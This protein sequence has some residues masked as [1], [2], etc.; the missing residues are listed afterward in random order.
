[1][2]QL[3]NISLMRI[4]HTDTA[5][6]RSLSKSNTF[7]ATFTTDQYQINQCFSTP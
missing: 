5:F 6:K 4:E 1:M 7:F 2:E 3:K